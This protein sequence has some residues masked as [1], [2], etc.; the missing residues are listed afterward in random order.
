MNCALVTFVFSQNV[1]NQSPVSWATNCGWVT[2]VF[3]QNVHNLPL[4]PPPFLSLSLSLPPPP[5]LPPSP[6]LSPSLPPEF[7]V[8][9]CWVRV[10]DSVQQESYLQPETNYIFVVRAQNAFSVSEP[11]PPSDPIHIEG[12]HP[13]NLKVERRVETQ[14]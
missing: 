1:L 8:S 11:S 3:S 10:S 9:Q 13:W 6:S 5:S 7:T 4:P 12:E 2:F 14:E